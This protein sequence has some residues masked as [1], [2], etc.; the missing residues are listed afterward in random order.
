[1]W[2]WVWW[3]EIWEGIE[4][5]MYCYATTLYI[6]LIKN[7]SICLNRWTWRRYSSTGKYTTRHTPHGPR[8]QRRHGARRVACFRSI[9]VAPRGLS[10][11]D[12]AGPHIAYCVEGKSA[13]YFVCII[14]LCKQSR[15]IFFEGNF[16]LVVR[17]FNLT[18]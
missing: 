17:T 15:K 2:I 10:A 11:T 3:S 9:V 4:P 16:L 5:T 13:A 8:G 18:A 14:L 1:M 12:S 7:T 6:V